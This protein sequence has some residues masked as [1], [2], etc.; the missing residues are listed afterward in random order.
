[1]GKVLGI[2]YRMLSTRLIK[3]AGFAKATAKTGAVNL[4]QRFGSALNLN[5]HFHM[6]FLDG[7][8]AG[9][10]HGK[11]HFHR[12]KAPTIEELKILAHT[13]SH[14]VARFLERKGLLERDAESSYLAL[15]PNDEDAMLQLEGHLT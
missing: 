3:K 13:L 11:M 9:N 2:V 6:L 8:Y 15:E 4:I 10:S 12:V 5:I 14:R 7:V 1:M